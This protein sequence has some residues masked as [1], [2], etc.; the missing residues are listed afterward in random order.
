MKRQGGFT[1]IELIVV[2]MILAILVATAAPKF[3]NF[4]KDARIAAL[5]G[6]KGAIDSG[7]QLVYGKSAIAGKE[8]VGTVGII[9]GNVEIIYGYPT[10]T[11]AGIGNAVTG[12]GDATS[13]TSDW[14][15]TPGAAGTGQITITFK[16]SSLGG[17]CNV[18]YTESKPVSGVIEPANAVVNSST[19]G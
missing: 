2:M 12:I 15:A 10:A 3:L 9:A 18:V 16:T 8:T 1:L 6:L 19:C 4:Q 13:T 14:L 5:Q 11:L 17:G 7:A